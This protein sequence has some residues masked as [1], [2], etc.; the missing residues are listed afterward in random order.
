MI[1]IDTKDVKINIPNPTKVDGAGVRHGTS[2]DL[3]HGLTILGTAVSAKPKSILELGVGRGFVTNILLDAIEFNGIGELTC[4]DNLHDDFPLTLFGNLRNR[5]AKII[6]PI[7]EKDFVFQTEENTYDFLMSDADHNH[8]GEWTDQIFKIMKPN[9]FMFFHDITNPG[10][11]NLLNYETRAKELNKPYYIF[12][13][14]SRFDERC[15]AGL[16]M[17]INTK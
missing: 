16:L 9:S 12:N 10:Y 5:G 4:V 7:S 11:P 17:I 6:E 14:E 1:N 8:A 2:I 15:W 13:Q 3:C